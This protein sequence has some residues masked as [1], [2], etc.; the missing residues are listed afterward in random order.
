NDELKK[1]GL[2][3]VK[4]RYVI[5]AGVPFGVRGT[6][7]MLRVERLREDDFGALR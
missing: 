2:A 5:T 7:N 4:D 3:D 6:T 1:S